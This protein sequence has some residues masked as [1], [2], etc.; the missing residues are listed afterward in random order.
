MKIK[1]DVYKFDSNN[2]G[3][4]WSR[5]VGLDYQIVNIHAF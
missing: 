4:S 5:N 2:G 3:G 1:I